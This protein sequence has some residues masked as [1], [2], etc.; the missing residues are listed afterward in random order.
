M[1]TVEEQLSN[2]KSV[3]F[4]KHNIIT[5]FVG[6]PL[7]VWA[8]TVLLSLHIFTIE[9][10][11]KTL[12]YTPAVIFFT[13]AMLYYLKLHF[14][15]AIGMLLYIAINIYLAS[16]VSNMESA[17]WIAIIA[18][19]VGWII[20]FIGHI[21]EKAK[22]AFLDD[23]MGLAIGPLFLMAET[24]FALGLEKNL[25]SNITPLAIEKR[26]LIERKNY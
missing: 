19:V 1:K 4:N 14:K 18:F 21:Y 22:P 5:H 23:I 16:L 3:H 10:T 20:Q 6:V 24:Y 17:L 12:S 11:G 13:I 25:A 9:I 2:Y 15:L 26:R 7:I 8:I